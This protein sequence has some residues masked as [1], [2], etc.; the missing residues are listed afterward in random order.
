VSGAGIR[1]RVARPQIL[2]VAPNLG[3]GHALDP[4]VAAL[5][6]LVRDRWARDQAERLAARN[7]LRVLRRTE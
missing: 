3:E 2:E 5:A 6:Q 4:V 7:R 1:V